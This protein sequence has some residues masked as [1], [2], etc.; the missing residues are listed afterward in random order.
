MT[1]HPLESA[2][3]RSIDAAPSEFEQY[4]R[5]LCCDT[6][7]SCPILTACELE[8]RTC[9]VEDATPRDRDAGPVGIAY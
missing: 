8:D 7:W 5:N 3:L 9:I 2:A 1:T 4:W 6:V